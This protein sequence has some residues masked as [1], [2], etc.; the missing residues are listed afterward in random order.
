M[1]FTPAHAQLNTKILIPHFI[2]EYYS[3]H[4]LRTRTKRG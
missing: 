2:K 4:S 1:F 3:Y